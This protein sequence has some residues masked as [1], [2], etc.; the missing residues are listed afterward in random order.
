M[1]LDTFMAAFGWCDHFSEEAWA[2]V[3]NH[4]LDTS[5]DATI[6]DVDDFCNNYREYSTS[7]FIDRFHDAHP[8]LDEMD[9][10]QVVEYIK[11][12]AGIIQVGY[13]GFHATGS[14]II[15]N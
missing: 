5:G 8:G 6:I 14:W 2:A 9:H 1:S 7:E 12:L 15:P 4:F 13:T 3:Y 10:E 11:S